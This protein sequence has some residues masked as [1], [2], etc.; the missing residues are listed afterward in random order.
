MDIVQKY[1]PSPSKQQL[2]III[3]P[4]PVTELDTGQNH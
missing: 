2:I 1:S 3:I 4:T